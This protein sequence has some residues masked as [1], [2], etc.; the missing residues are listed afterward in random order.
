MKSVVIKAFNGTGKDKVL[1]GDRTVDMPET[2]EEAVKLFGEEDTLDY[3]TSSYTIE[4]Q[5]Q[6]RAGTTMSARQ[7]L[8]ALEAFVKANPES[9]VAKTLETLKITFAAPKENAQ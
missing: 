9:E 6:I 2:T 1:A 7:Q 4:I 3:I 5:R 8:R